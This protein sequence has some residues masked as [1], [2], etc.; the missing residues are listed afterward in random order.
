MVQRNIAER[1]GSGRIRLDND[2]YIQR[3]QGV[4]LGLNFWISKS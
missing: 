4:Q 2:L 1:T 3:D